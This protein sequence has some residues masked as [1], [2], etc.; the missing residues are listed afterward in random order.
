MSQVRAR[1]GV[2]AVPWQGQPGQEENR[3]ASPSKQQGVDPPTTSAELAYN[4]NVEGDKVQDA[5]AEVGN[6]D[7][8]L[9]DL[10]QLEELHD[11]AE[12]MKALGNKHMAA[13]VCHR[14]YISG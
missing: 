11:E 13:Q 3:I 2:G 5:S 7:D 12:R 1:K 4:T 14:R 8:A 9:L 10:D 6:G